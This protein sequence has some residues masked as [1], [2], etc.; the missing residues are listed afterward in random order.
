MNR[1]KNKKLIIILSVIIVVI[2]IF[3]FLFFWSNRKFEVA[4]NVGDEYLNALTIKK[5]DKIDKLPT[6]TK[7]GFIFD[8]WY[9]GKVLFDSDTEITEDLE[10]TAK[11]VKSIYTITINDGKKDK[12]IEVKYKENVKKPKTPKKTGYVFV[13]W[14]VGDDEYD[15]NTPV[16]DDIKIEAKWTKKEEISYKVEHYLMNKTGK[17]DETPVDTNKLVGNADS[18]V[19]PKTKSYRGYIAPKVQKIK[20]NK[21]NIVVKYYYDLEEYTLSIETSKGIE[22]ATGAGK[23]FYNDE[24]KIN[25]TLKPGY[26]FVSYSE[27][28]NNSIY[29]MPDKDVKIVLTAKPIT[30]KINY[31]L[32]NG[33][34]NE[35][36]PLKYN[37]EAKEIVLNN[38]TKE[39]YTFVGWYNDSDKLVETIPSGSIGDITLTAKYTA[40]T[41]DV[42]Y[43]ANTGVGEMDNQTLTYDEDAKLNANEFT[44]KYTLTYD[45]GYNDLSDTEDK[46][47][48]F[49]GWATTADGEVV[50]ANEADVKNLATNGTFNLYAKWENPT[51]SLDEEPT[52]DGYTFKGWSTTRDGSNIVGTLELTED[53]TV[54]AVWETIEYTITYNL[55]G[56]VEETNPTKYTIES[57]TITLS[58]ATKTGYTFDG[59]Y[60]NSDTKVETINKG[61]IG[62]ITLT[63]KYTPITYNITYNLD[64]GEENTNPTTYTIE[65][66][67]ITLSDATKTGYTFDGWYDNTDTKVETINKGSVGN[68]ILTAKYTANTYDVIFNA[69]TGIGSMSNQILTYDVDAKLNANEF[70]KKYTLTYDYGYND[71]SNTEDKVNN[72]LGWATTS[73][74]AVEYSNE[75]NVKNLAPSGVYNLYAKWENPTATLDKTITKDGYTFM[76]WSTTADGSNIVEILELTEDTTV[77]AVWEA[78]EY[79]IAYDLDGGTLES[80]VT[81]PS[82]YT[83]IDNITLNNP[84]KVGYTFVGWE[85]NGATYPQFTINN[86]IGD[87]SVK[88]IYTPNIDTQYKVQYYFMDTDGNYLDNPDEEKVL[89]GVTDALTQTIVNNYLG[90]QTPVLNQE[91]IK[92]DGSTVITYR[93]IRNQHTLTVVAGEG[94]ASATGTNKYYYDKEINLSA[95][96]EDGYELVRWSNGLNGENVQVTM[97]DYDMTITASASLI[98]YEINY[99]LDGG[100]VTSSLPTSYT[101][102]TT[103]LEIVNPTRIGYTFKGW[104]IN[105]EDPIKDLVI[106]NQSGNLNLKAVWE[107]NSSTIGFNTHGGSAVTSIVQNYGTTVVAPEDPTRVGYIFDGWYTSTNYYDSELYVFNTMPD[108]GLELHAKWVPITYTV[109]FDG[110]SST[111]SMTSQLLTYDISVNLNSNE[112]TKVGYSFVGWEYNGTTYTDGQEVVNLTSEN[113][114]TITLVAKWT[115]VEY[116]ITYDKN[117]GVE[118]TNPETYTIESDNITLSEATKTGYTF[119]GWYDNSDTKVE[120][121]DK[122]S[123]GNITLTAKYTPI[124]YN[125]TYNLDGGEENTNPTI[126]TIESNTI[127]LSDATKTG[128]TFD[129]WYD[130]TDTKV[131]TIN[132]GSVGN[133]TLTAKYTANTYDVIYNANTGIG[134]MSN[135][136]LT[137]DVDAK[138]NANEFTKKYTLTY[139]YGYNDLSNTEDKVNNFLGWATTADGAVEYANEA[140]VKNLATNGVYNLYA[141]WENPTVT[142]DKTITRDGY[143]FMGWSTTNDGSN[144]VDTLELTEDTTVYAV[145]EAVEYTITYNLDGG[146]LESGV[147]NPSKYTII[148]NI[149]LN[150]PKKVGYTFSKW[151]INGTDNDGTITNTFGDL[152]IKAVYTPNTNT[153]YKVNHYLMDLDGTNYTLEETEELTGTTASVV[154]PSVKTYTGFT[155]PSTNDLTISPDGTSEIDYY[156]TRNQYTLTLESDEGIQSVTGGKSYYYGET[157][158]IS[159]TPKDGYTFDKWSSDVTTMPASNLTINAISKLIEYTITYDLDG[160]TLESGITNPSKYTIIDNITLNEPTK[161]GYIFSKWLINGTDNDGTITNTFGDLE[162][163]A[164]YTPNTYEVS[165]NGNGATSGTMTNSSHTYDVSSNLTTNAYAKQYNIKYHYN[166]DVTADKTTTVDFEFGGWSEEANGEVKYANEASVKNLT[167][168]GTKELFAIWNMTLETPI[169]DGYKFVG[170]S[171]TN[172]DTNLITNSSQL[173]DNMELYAIWYIIPKIESIGFD[174]Y[175]DEEC[176]QPYGIDPFVKGEDTFYVALPDDAF[177]DINSVKMNFNTEVYLNKDNTHDENYTEVITKNSNEVGFYIQSIKV[178]AT[179]TDSIDYGKIWIGS[180]NTKNGFAVRN[181]YKAV[182]LGVTPRNIGIAN[183]FAKTDKGV[184]T[185]Q[186]I[187]RTENING[188]NYLFFS[189]KSH[190]NITINFKGNGKVLKTL[191]VPKGSIIPDIKKINVAGYEFLGWYTD[192]SYT[193]LFDFSKINKESI[194]IYGKYEKIPADTN[195][196]IPGN[197]VLEICDYADLIGFADLLNEGTTFEG[198]TIKLVCDIGLDNS[199]WTPLSGFKGTFDGNNHTISNLKIVGTSH[200]VGF[201]NK[202]SGTAK[203]HNLKFENAKVSSTYYYV[204]VV[205]GEIEGNVVIENVSLNN[206]EVKSKQYAG[207]IT[208]RALGGTIK[209]SSVTNAKIHSDNG[210]LGG[211]VGQTTKN[212]ILSNLIVQGELSRVWAF[213]ATD[214]GGI[215]GDISDASGTLIMN[216]LIFIGTTSGSAFGSPSAILGRIDKGDANF[217]A[218]STWFYDKTIG[219]SFSDSDYNGTGKTTDELKTASTYAGW[220]TNIWEFT[221]GAYPTLKWMK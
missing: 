177:M 110:N 124:T 216:N 137:Y 85:Y 217:D 38:P 4:L 199:E 58:D 66:D 80:G 69:N 127:T 50:Y 185:T 1:K 192:E 30:Y 77:Y 36:N 155:S 158:S 63:A 145:W 159:A 5:G 47:N 76:G 97:P 201:F 102:K 91:I 59:W 56:G 178:K 186:Y 193:T 103:D 179:D 113:E 161:T 31:N 62:N 105:D 188:I 92:G 173:S 135:Q 15:F 45:Y 2:A 172:D 166:D 78:I 79:S 24:I 219:T 11:W 146:T 108:H 187:S 17:Y 22:S 170:W 129:G 126:Y 109:E 28:L 34:L 43:N 131:E 16:T 51:A 99:D 154:T 55:D 144:I 71:L 169:R 95:N 74:G 132:K 149:T 70:T 23:H 189:E 100:S 151:V 106:S 37:V 150:N 130:N 27:K 6:P 46:A 167:A 19:S 141:K 88:A 8:G 14:F 123:I 65:S 96:L 136:I 98:N 197:D 156:Y 60:D 32:D 182:D 133:I 211:I 190:P 171:S 83:I 214:L 116:T 162:V 220:D 10:L 148:D 29:T 117:G 191:T 53:T 195:W 39:G 213:N 7:D 184:L 206:I 18:T 152:E 35:E 174:L 122:G 202:L 221:D 125:I 168:S 42:V 176:T 212:V 64:G 61:S 26:E 200:Y 86:R 94:I 57:N 160:G 73:D 82:K 140:D 139:D 138:L 3:L 203:V 20:L 89:T 218:K 68:I 215:V 40:N 9:N 210:D 194:T 72:F 25:Y 114:S 165:Y 208:G 120:I 163:K 75:A 93:Y 33:V 142:I 107:I 204:G 81:N 49:L 153:P 52:R 90:F 209:N 87:I 12:T 196:Y 198:K 134:S 115:P 44:K 48:E 21:E 205:A 111:G 119:D 104:S 84:N 41:Y 207:G 143:T 118:E 101:I 13:G 180:D 183:N 164:V 121:I 128:Y 54:Y 181:Y 112:F 157:I 175:K 147:T 67:T